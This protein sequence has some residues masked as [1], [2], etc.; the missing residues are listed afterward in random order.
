VRLLD[1]IRARIPN[2]ALR[3]TFIVG[4]PGETTLDF[5]QLEE[6]VEEIGFDHLGVFTYSH[7]EDTS[8]YALKDDVP[9]AVKKRRQERL[10]ALQK[11]IVGAR[12]K[13]RVGE[14]ARMVVDGSSPEHEL[15]IAGRLSGQAP[16]IDPVVYLTDV[17]PSTVTPGMFLDVEIVGSQDYDLVATPVLPA[18]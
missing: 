18:P 9:A 7:E 16:E 1:N 8:A 14:R 17:D 13:R 10:M 11:K 4:F 5:A 15:V 12:Q 6:F 3:T 2:V